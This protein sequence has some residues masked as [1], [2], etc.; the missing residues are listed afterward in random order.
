M[1]RS[2]E[3]L[4]DVDNFITQSHIRQGR[5]NRGYS[6]AFDVSAK[7]KI[8]HF[9]K[10][11]R[12]VIDKAE[13]DDRKR[14]ALYARIGALQTEVDRVRT[15]FEAFG[16]FAIEA[17][18]ILGEMGKQIEPLTNSIAR[19]FGTAKSYEDANPA[20]PPPK[21][22]KKISPPKKAPKPELD[23]DIPF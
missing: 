8:A 7:R 12:D 18:G 3:F 13:L 4:G 1:R 20:L 5:R 14:E 9:L 11:I 6:V 16:A 21:V 19:I 22:P 10:Q 23:D 2:L 15:R 17:A